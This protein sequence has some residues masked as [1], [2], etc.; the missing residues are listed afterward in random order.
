MKTIPFWCRTPP[1]VN[2]EVSY[3][4][5]LLY[6]STQKHIHKF[7][8]FY[9]FIIYSQISEIGKYLRKNKAT[10]NLTVRGVQNLV[11]ELETRPRIELFRSHPVCFD[12]V[13]CIQTFRKSALIVQSS[14]KLAR[15]MSCLKQGSHQS[16]NSGKFLKTFSSQG[17]Q[18]KTGSLQP[19]SGKK[20]SNQGT[21]F[22]TI[23]KPFNLM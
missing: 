19:K 5:I 1:I 13:D 15:P 4:K 14:Y 18:G 2:S 22:K 11:L 23:F 6:E 10:S 7:Q 12:T 20:I 16:G 9:L 8:F 3:P 21:F 17:N